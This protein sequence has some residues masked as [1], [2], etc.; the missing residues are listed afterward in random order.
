MNKNN[1]L[2]QFYTNPK[3]SDYI[4]NTIFKCFP[5]FKS[6]SFIEPSAGCGN[7][8]DSLLRQGIKKSN[9]M[10][11]DIAPVGD[12]KIIKA[13]YLTKKIKFN[14]NQIIIGN[15]PFGKKGKLAIEFINK[16]LSEAPIVAM[17]LPKLFKRF[18]VHKQ[19]IDSAKLIYEIDLEPNS[20]LVNNKEYSV[21]C[22]FQIWT[23]PSIKTYCTNKRIYFKKQ[24]VSSDFI[25]FIHNNTKE[26]EKYFNKN[27]Y[28]WDFAVYRQGFYDYQRKFI[29]SKQL[30][31]NRQ[32]LF[33]KAN[34][35][36]AKDILKNLD[37]EKI[38][39]NNTTVFGFSLTDLLEEY[40]YLK[41]IYILNKLLE[42]F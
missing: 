36:I 31:K 24:T 6:Y 10:A 18:S 11:F 37:F 19:I 8:I 20:F 22:I 34:N 1:K 30:K 4:V 42:C 29:D 14:S 35:K 23:L 16:G 5:S 2:D 40:N 41:K 26:T 27:K 28:N 25:T 12:T 9:I 17:I 21:N 13:N 3:V 32:Y 39:K 15:P 38:S 7:F 33:V